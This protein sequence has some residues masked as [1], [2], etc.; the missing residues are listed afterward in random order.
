MNDVDTT[1]YSIR[2]KVVHAFVTFLFLLVQFSV[3]LAVAGA[4]M[5][6]SYLYI[7]NF[8]QHILNKMMLDKLMKLNLLNAGTMI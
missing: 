1:S 2:N 7:E 3:S 4:K 6:Y 8:L 5:I